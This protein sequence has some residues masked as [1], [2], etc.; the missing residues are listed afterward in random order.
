MHVGVFTNMGLGYL[1]YTLFNSCF[2]YHR[3]AFYI[4]VTN[5]DE[6]DKPGDCFRLK[7]LAA[8]YLF[9]P[10]F[11]A[12]QWSQPASRRRARR[13]DQLG[14]FTNKNVR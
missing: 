11:L 4:L 9:T 3:L 13:S 7:Q 10:L 12:T 6:L 14:A 5:E 2:H 1:F 8:L